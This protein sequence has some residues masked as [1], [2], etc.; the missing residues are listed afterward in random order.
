MVIL[1][2]SAS[3]IRRILAILEAIDIESY[4]EELA[5]FKIEH[6][7]AATIADQ[8]SEI[9]GG[10]VASSASSSRASSNARTRARQAQQT[11]SGPSQ[12][13]AAALRLRRFAPLRGWS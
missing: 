13:A 7:D 2:E 8:I 4:Q 11:A 1:T 5:V 9:Y 6:A 12:S 3:N 10:E